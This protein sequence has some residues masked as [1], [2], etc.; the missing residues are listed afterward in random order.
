MLKSIFIEFISRIT[1]LLETDL[2]GKEAHQKMESAFRHKTGQI[3][4]DAKAKQ[5]AVLIL[6]YPNET[7]EICT[8]FTLKQSGI[9]L[10]SNQ[11][12]LPG[13]RFEQEDGT[14]QNTALRESFEE[15]GVLPSSV[16][17]IGRLSQLIIPRSQFVVNTFVGYTLTKPDFKIQENEVAELYEVRLA[18]FFRQ[19]NKSS[20][21]IHDEQ[22]NS[23]HAP[24]Y[25]VNN[26]HLWG[27]TAM[28]MAEMEEILRV[29]GLIS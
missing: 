25:Q 29:G 10:H 13:G 21:Q 15:I 6:L 16:T 5:S 27:A 8:V 11:I 9:G 19:S 17:V 24:S 18:D 7:G 14:L 26:R 12:S 20:F 23:F 2:P 3:W 28:I 22:G 4:D 1:S